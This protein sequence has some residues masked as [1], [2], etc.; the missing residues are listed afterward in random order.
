MWG[1]VYFYLFLLAAVLGI[2]AGLNALILLVPPVASLFH[3][4][5]LKMEG[6]LAIALVAAMLAGLLAV[7]KGR[8]RARFTR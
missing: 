5:A 2:T 1:I 4:V 3:F 6:I 7:T 8:F